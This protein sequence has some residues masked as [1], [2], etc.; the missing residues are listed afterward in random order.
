MQGPGS[1]GGSKSF[2]LLKGKG[3]QPEPEVFSNE[4][5]KSWL[6]RSIS[7]QET[8]SN[9]CMVLYGD[10]GVGKSGAVLD[11]RTD[12]EITEGRKV[13]VIDIDASCAPLKAKFWK[14]DD[15]VIILDPTT[16]QADGT[17]DYVTTYNKLLA[18]I[19]Y[20]TDEQDEMNLQAVVLDGLD[21]L[22]KMCEYVMRYEDLKV[23]PDTQIKDQWQWTRRNRRYNTVVILMKH[24]RCDRY[25]T[26]HLKEIKE[27]RGGQLST[28][29]KVPDWEKQTP[30]IMFQRVLLTRTSSE[31]V[32]TFTA[33]IEKAKG[34][35]EL[36]GN[37]YLVAEVQKGKATWNGLKE[38]YKDIKG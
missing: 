6:D 38:L 23:D 1:G 25:F 11:C 22:L 8:N 16:L 27:Y 12:E 29:E 35:L 19:R 2:G 24:L 36:E 7:V 34:A 28:K 13:I 17:I 30:G 3:D 32:T 4:D 18:L 20:I 9:I 14:D 37:E 15:N 33:K 21:S 10:D 31:G 5:V 26:T